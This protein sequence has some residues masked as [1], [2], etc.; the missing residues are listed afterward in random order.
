MSFKLSSETTDNNII[1]TTHEES[2]NE[3]NADA[4]LANALKI[5]KTING[6]I[7]INLEETQNIDSAGVNKLMRLKTCIGVY[8]KSLYICN[9]KM[10]KSRNENNAWVFV[11]ILNIYDDLESALSA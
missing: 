8:G 10:D 4:F 7:I 11:D 2:L 3:S 9:M 5:S 1:I 6:K